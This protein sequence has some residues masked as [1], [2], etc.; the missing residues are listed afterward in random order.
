MTVT[1]LTAVVMHTCYQLTMEP[2][3]VQTTTLLLFTFG[4]ID[5]IN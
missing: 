3:F 4:E 1:M 2:K 5:A